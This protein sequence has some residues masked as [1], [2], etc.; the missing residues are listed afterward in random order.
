MY[1]IQLLL[2]V[3]T[4]STSLAPPSKYVGR[5]G[6]LHVESHSRYLDV[7]A[8]NYQVYSEINPTSGDVII[9]GLTKSFEFK[10]GAL[11]QAFNSDRFDMRAFD[12]FR[13]EGDIKDLS[14]VD[15][16]QAGSYPIEVEGFLYMGDY[17]RKTSA[18][19]TILV[20]ADGSARAET[21]FVMRIEEESMNTI[22]RLMR[23]KLPSMVAL[24]ADDLGIS[25]DIQ[26]E[27]KT[28]MR[29]RR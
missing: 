8:D 29:P 6:H 5:T 19:G 10:L 18:S 11:D 12:K 22:N 1:F 20:L 25:R 23:E 9:R 14:S 17:K 4:T 13:Y 16:D 27:L 15:W 3:L 28:N 7:I 26:L 2:L 21:S 24:D